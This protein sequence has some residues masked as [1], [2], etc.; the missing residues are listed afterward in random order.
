MASTL[1]ADIRTRQDALPHHLW[2]CGACR[3]PPVS[4]SAWKHTAHVTAVEQCA[5]HPAG[6]FGPVGLFACS[7]YCCCTY[8]PSCIFLN[9]TQA[10][11]CPDNLSH[12]L[13]LQRLPH[14]GSLCSAVLWQHLKHVYKH[15]ASLRPL[16]ARLQGLRAHARDLPWALRGAD[17]PDM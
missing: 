8:R 17:L 10:S 9:S 3:P 15:T 13:T 2:D 1:P 7:C 4:V 14:Q 12:V 6:A 16:S 5:V 11:L